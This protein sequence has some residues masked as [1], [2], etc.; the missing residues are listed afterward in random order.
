MDRR[1]YGCKG[2][3]GG[4]TLALAVCVLSVM[5]TD[6]PSINL[7]IWAKHLHHTQTYT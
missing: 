4:L 2:D 1:L 7:V 5:E 6:T 3:L